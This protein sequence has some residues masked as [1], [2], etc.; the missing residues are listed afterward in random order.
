VGVILAVLGLWR[1]LT[2][3]QICAFEPEA[4][5]RPSTGLVGFFGF[6][7]DVGGLVLCIIGL[8]LFVVA[9]GDVLDRG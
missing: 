3:F 4:V 7:S 2:T 6:L 1:F 8:A 9:L 5:S